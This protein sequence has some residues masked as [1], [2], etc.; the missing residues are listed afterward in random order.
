M[1]NMNKN[2]YLDDI[3]KT[4]NS[5][6]EIINVREETHGDKKQNHQN[7][8]NFWNSYLK[9]KGI[10]EKEITPFDVAIMMSLLK[11]A[12]MQSGSDN[13]DDIFDA[14]GYLIISSILR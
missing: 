5:I 10:V 8:A 13:N 9:G 2:E 11:I 1:K 6:K 4:I 12:R 3:N 14:A 7:I